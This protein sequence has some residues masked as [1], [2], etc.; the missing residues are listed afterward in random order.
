MILVHYACLAHQFMYPRIAFVKI[1]NVVFFLGETSYTFP[2]LAVKRKT[3]SRSADCMAF[4]TVKRPGMENGCLRVFNH[5]CPGPDEKRCQPWNCRDIN[6]VDDGTVPL[7]LYH[8]FYTTHHFVYT[9]IHSQAAK[10]QTVIFS[11]SVT[12]SHNGSFNQG[13]TR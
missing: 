1:R 3:V 2:D 9:I 7:A 11:N 12:R 6:K 4:V 5:T 8:R 13:G 10:F